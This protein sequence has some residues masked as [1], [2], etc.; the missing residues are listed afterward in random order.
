MVGR[1]ARKRQRERE[2]DN[3]ERERKTELRVHIT[4]YEPQSPERIGVGGWT[5]PD[6]YGTETHSVRASG[7]LAAGVQTS[8][9]ESSRGSAFLLVS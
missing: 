2:R 6:I 8:G 5:Q 4:L 1:Q 7:S 9:S 3:N